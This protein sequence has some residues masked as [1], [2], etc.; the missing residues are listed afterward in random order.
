L[1]SSSTTSSHHKNKLQIKYDTKIYW[2]V[3]N[4]Y[5]CHFF[6]LANHNHIKNLWKFF[7]FNSDDENHKTKMSLSIS[8][9]VCLT[10]VNLLWLQHH[11]LDQLIRCC[12][13]YKKIN[14]K[15]YF[16]QLM[17]SALPHATLDGYL[18]KFRNG[19]I[20]FFYWQMN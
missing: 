7:H 5:R 8:F 11:H 10:C 20:L 18:D 1:I 15:F 12:L 2:N 19:W 6:Y 17:T 9:F 13:Y 3:Y 16:F 14:N 4:F